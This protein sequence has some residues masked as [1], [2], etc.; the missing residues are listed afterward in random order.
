MRQTL[1]RRTRTRTL[2][3]K[4]T[5]FELL[6]LS[7]LFRPRFNM[8]ARFPGGRSAIGAGCGKCTAIAWYARDA[9]T[10]NR[11]PACLDMKPPQQP[12]TSSVLQNRN[13]SDTQNT[14]QRKQMSHFHP[15]VEVHPHHSDDHTGVPACSQY[16]SKP[17]F[18]TLSH[19]PADD[20]STQHW[21][22]LIAVPEILYS[23]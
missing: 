8:Q 4:K 9:I 5:L 10:I 12:R 17:Y 13:F 19:P 6:S 2:R 20:A 22:A 21:I 7:Y 23:C 16:T 1:Q 14:P 15:C 18:T 11:L 3:S